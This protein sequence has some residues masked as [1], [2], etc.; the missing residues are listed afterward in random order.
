MAGE[1]GQLLEVTVPASADLSSFQY[2][3][4]V[5]TSSGS[6]GTHAEVVGTAATA[7]FGILTNKPA[8]ANRAARVCIQGITKLEAVSAIAIGDIVTVAGAGGRGS[9][10]VAT[11]LTAGTGWAIGRALS[12]AAASGDIF[13]VYVNPFF[14]NRA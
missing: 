2:R 9:A 13:E 14:Y 11:P 12:R 3:G 4:I 6:A 7:T 8:A 5:L 1:R 10:L